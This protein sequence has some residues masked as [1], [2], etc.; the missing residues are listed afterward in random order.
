M[1]FEDYV[2]REWPSDVPNDCTAFGQR[3]KGLHRS[4]LTR[5][6]LLPELP[7]VCAA[8]AEV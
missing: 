7:N 2:V 6:R 5:G 8:V 1:D 3:G 4:G